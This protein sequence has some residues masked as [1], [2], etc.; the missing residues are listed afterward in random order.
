MG[1]LCFI[2]KFW[3]FSFVISL[4]ILTFN[5]N[6]V[7][8]MFQWNN[9]TTL[10]W[11]NGCDFLGNDLKNVQIPAERCGPTCEMDDYCSHFAW[12]K[13]KVNFCYH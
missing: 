11:A 5:A 1:G 7:N 2:N 9:E 6:N 13:Y 4:F 12:T 10:L 8:A 3:Q